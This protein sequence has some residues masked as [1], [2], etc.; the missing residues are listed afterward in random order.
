M[1]PDTANYATL[2]NLAQFHGLTEHKTINLIMGHIMERPN[3]VN[4][5]FKAFRPA[6]RM[7]QPEE[8]EF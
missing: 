3:E 1:I 6:N 7:G 8:Q 2:K 5:Q 4:P